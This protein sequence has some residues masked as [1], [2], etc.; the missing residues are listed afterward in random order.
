MLNYAN[1]LYYKW[2]I[3]V[4]WTF[5]VYVLKIIH[6]IAECTTYVEEMFISISIF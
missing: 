4:S 5:N 3:G 1:W 2:I 6:F